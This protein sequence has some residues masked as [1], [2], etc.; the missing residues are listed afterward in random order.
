M[1][2][3]H[4]AY[5]QLSLAFVWLFQRDA[6]RSLQAARKAL[7]Q[8]QREPDAHY[9]E[10][11]ALCVSCPAEN[12]SRLEVEAILRR[13]AVARRLPNAGAHIDLLTALVIA[14]YYSPRYLTP[15]ASP[16]EMLVQ[17]LSPGRRFDSS[18]NMRVIDLEPPLDKTFGP[19]QA[20]MA[21]YF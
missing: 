10:A 14:N 6:T 3:P 15:P 2:S 7:D 18:E 4:N 11:L 5:N 8:L 19:N 20:L 13:L 21:R 12:R 1:I 9:A 17:G 16:D